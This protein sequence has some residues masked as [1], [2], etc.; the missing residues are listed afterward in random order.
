[1]LTRLET[2]C[3]LFICL[4]LL[5]GT[6]RAEI[7]T[8]DAMDAGFV[9]IEGGSAKGDGTVAPPATFNYSVGQEVHF[10][11]G[12]L[13]G[14]LEFM[15]RKNYFV[16][17]LAGVSEPITSASLM[18]Y[19]GPDTG[20]DYPGGEHGYESLDPFE[21]YALLETTDPGMALG[22]IDD[23]LVGNLT[24]G[25]GAFDDPTD[26]LVIAAMDLYGI[27]GDGAPLATITTTSDDDDT[28][29]MI[30]FT[31]IGV[32]YLN[33]FPGGPVVLAGELTTVG[34]VDTTEL[35]FGF[36]GPDLLG[37]TTPGFVPKLIVTTIPEPAGATVVIVAF[38][39]LANVRRRRSA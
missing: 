2:S 39:L 18:V 19:M 33:M 13:T 36:T 27:L 8:V 29:L 15:L 24:G 1:M 31:P 25:P 9:T 10:D 14:S 16:F 7:V 35:I 32:D 5:P 34:G 28:F 20:P 3:L 4:F 12:S 21:D 26:P 38:G 11:D 17:D 22:I 23:L 30:D 37:G 6:T